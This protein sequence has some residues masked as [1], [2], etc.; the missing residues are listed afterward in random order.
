MNWKYFLDNETLLNS[1]IAIAILLGF[2]LVR[3]LF[4]KYLFKFILNIAKKTPTDF[5]TNVWLSFEHPIRWLFVVIG[6]YIA[7]QYFPYIDPT[8]SLFIK[9][10]RSSIILLITW[11]LYNL[12]SA[13][14]F[15][16]HSMNKR[17]NFEID[18]ILIPFL[19]KAIRVVIILISITIIA[20]EFDYDING[21]IAGLGLG[22]LAFALAAQDALKN[23]IAG[24]VII[25]EKPFSIGEWILTP[26][27]EGTVEDITFRSTKVRT[28]AQ[29]LVTV[30]NSTLANENI[31][32][33]SKM[34]KRR[35]EFTLGV[36]YGT[37]TSRLEKVINRIKDMLENNPDIHKE[38][39]FVTFDRFSDSSLDLFLYFFTNT[40]VWGEFLQIKQDINFNIL[41]IL[42]EEGVEIAFPSQ[43]L[44]VEEQTGNNYSVAQGK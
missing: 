37:P 20:Q 11:G 13:S 39:I 17:L 40:T 24:I 30:P 6:V 1:V 8:N 19:S 23:L 2:L 41:R 5:L 42:E 15:L 43:T 34:G 35:I 26:S 3:K 22:G 32:N 16:F 25:F 28:F 9:F 14:S 38:T 36:K 44:Y 27:V 29:A 4:S 7:A 18:Q 10:Y 31:T 21:F 12:S 33:W